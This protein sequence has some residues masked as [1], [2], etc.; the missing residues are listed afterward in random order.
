MFSVII[1][2][3]DIV[4]YQGFGWEIHQDPWL[5][6]YV[7]DCP[8]RPTLLLYFLTVWWQI[9]KLQIWKTHLPIIIMITLGFISWRQMFEWKGSWS[10]KYSN[11]F[12]ELHGCPI[13][14][15]VLYKE[16]PK[17]FVKLHHASRTF[18]RTFID[19]F[20]KRQDFHVLMLKPA[21]LFPIKAIT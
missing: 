10:Q 20:Q 17:L 6:S 16:K 8:A 4:T 15:S 18:W 5:C 11:S 12:E 13:Q 14:H 7:V 2:A 9:A 1:T 21:S 19:N 3:L